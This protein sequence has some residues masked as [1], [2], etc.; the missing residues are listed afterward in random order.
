MGARGVA[1]PVRLRCKI[2]IYVGAIHAQRPVPRTVRVRLVGSYLLSG[3]GKLI[4]CA[5]AARS[6]R[7]TLHRLP[8]Q[9]SFND[10]GAIGNT[11]IPARYATGN[12]DAAG[13]DAARAGP[14][15][16]DSRSDVISRDEV[17]ILQRER[18]GR[19]RSHLDTTGNDQVHCGS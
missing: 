12:V 1:Y 9:E 8:V 13:R 2:C 18:I 5:T 16:S 11:L 6:R 7:R 10:V 4:E 17:V 19:T 3:N 14:S 15:Q